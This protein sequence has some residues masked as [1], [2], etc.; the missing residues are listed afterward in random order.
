MIQ[1]S[2]KKCQNNMW[3][4]FLNVDLSNAHFDK[5]NG[6]YIIWQNSS[7][8][9]IRVGQGIIKDRIADHRTNRDITAYN[10]LCV[11]WAPLLSKYRDGVERYLANSLKPKIGDTFPEVIPIEVNLP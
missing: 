2:W 10:D 9:T 1:L 6:V 11:T 8:S 3:C 5:M 4:S 7:G